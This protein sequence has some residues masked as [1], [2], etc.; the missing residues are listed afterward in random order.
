MQDQHRMNV[1]DR[2]RMTAALIIRIVSFIT[3]GCMLVFGVIILTGF[4]IPAYIPENF[5]LI[6]GCI[7]IL[8]AVFRLIT[9]WMKVH[10][11]KHSEE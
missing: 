1:R 10:N 7:I 5:R 3:A 9:T 8:Y 11:E 6:I 2:S 4:G